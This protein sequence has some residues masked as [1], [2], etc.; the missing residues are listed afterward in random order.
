[1]AGTGGTIDTSKVFFA[2]TRE[3]F[4]ADTCTRRFFSRLYGLDVESGT[5]GLF[6]LET[7]TA[8]LDNPLEL[9]EGRVTGLY[10]RDDH[11]YVGKSGGVDL[12]GETQVLGSEEWEPKEVPEGT[13][14]IQVLVRGF[15]ISPF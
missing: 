8:E 1:M 2:A 10:M 7:Q 11:L 4:D 9:G 3:S 5:V 12:H 15:R 14:T 6:D 13:G